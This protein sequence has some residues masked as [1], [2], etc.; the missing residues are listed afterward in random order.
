MEGFNQPCKK[1][2]I[3]EHPNGTTSFPESYLEYFPDIVVLRREN[4]RCFTKETRETLLSKKISFTS[5]KNWYP[6]AER[7]VEENKFLTFPSALIPVQ[8]PELLGDAIQKLGGSIFVR[9]GSLSPKF[10]EPVETPEQV[11]SVLSESERTR[12]CLENKD[13]VFFL[14]KYENFPKEKEFRLFIRK[15]KL[16]A[17]SRYDPEANCDMAAEDVKRRISRWFRNLCLD[18]LLSFQ[19]CC[20]DVV[21]WDEKKKVSLFGDGV[22]LIEYN[23][24]GEDSVSGSCLFHWEKDWEVLTKGDAVTRC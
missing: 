20:L 4:G 11:L 17:I 15:G 10:F 2:N 16:R 5:A 14:R 6:D 1:T 23:S 7:G 18:G 24:Y 12:D 19:D 3:K 13:E 8:N 22:F 21:L 9:L